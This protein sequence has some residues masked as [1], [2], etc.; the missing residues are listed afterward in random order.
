[1]PWPIERKATPTR[2]RGS[3]SGALHMVTWKF[4][5]INFVNAGI[6]GSRFDPDKDGL[7]RCAG[8]RY[9]CWPMRRGKQDVCGRRLGIS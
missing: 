3:A 1:M 8:S 9:D 4:V 6:K 2:H 7:L 5:I